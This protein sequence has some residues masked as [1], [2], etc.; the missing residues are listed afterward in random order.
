MSAWPRLHYLYTTRSM[1]LEYIHLSFSYS[2]SLPWLAISDSLVLPTALLLRPPE[3][4]QCLS[5]K[6][7]PGQLATLFL[8]PRC[9][10]C[11]SLVVLAHPGKMNALVGK[12]VNQKSPI[13]QVTAPF[14]LT[15]SPNS[16][17][18]AQ[19]L[20]YRWSSDCLGYA[21]IDQLLIG[22]LAPSYLGPHIV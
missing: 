9:P 22:M 8:S 6:K 2:L 5:N 12:P 21:G 4:S 11:N 19:N 14:Q 3:V 10:P 13:T 15:A 7:I 17:E 20:S 16:R 18:L 1:R